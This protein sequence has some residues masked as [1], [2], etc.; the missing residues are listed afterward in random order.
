MEIKKLLI[1]T[2][3]LL[4]AACS[5]GNTSED[6]S[7]NADQ[8][9]LTLGVAPY[10]TAVPSPILEIAATATVSP[11]LAGCPA[12][13]QPANST[14]T[15]YDLYV[16]L[17]VVEHAGYIEERIVFPNQTGSPLTELA[18]VVDPNWID[19]VFSIYE[20][21]LGGAQSET[22]TLEGGLLR[23]P[24]EV[25]LPDGCSLELD[26]S[27]HLE[28]PAQAG[29]FGYTE[30]QLVLTNWYPFVPPYTPSQGWITHPRAEFGEYLVYPTADFTVT[31]ELSNP[32]EGVLIAAPAPAV[33][34]DGRYHYT[35]QGARMFSFAV[36][37][38]YA[39]RQRQYNGIDISVYTNMATRAAV[40]A[41]LSAAADALNF[42]E[43]TIGP[44]PFESLAIV[45]LDMYDGLES[46][47]IFY[48]SNHVFGTYN[49]SPRNMLIYLV[50]HEIS[51]NWW[52]SQVGND[53]AIEP[54]LDEALATYS[55]KLFYEQAFPE[56]SPWW[57]EYRIGQWDPE[58]W[59]D[60]SVYSYS[61]YEPYRQAVYL[62]GVE[63]LDALRQRMGDEAFL[64][65]LHS[66]LEQGRYRVMTADDFFS[67]LEEK[68][69][70]EID[71]LLAEY[72][73]SR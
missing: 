56:H 13:Y 27:Y 59:V 52:F 31:L 44:Y 43:S 69:P 20:L 48:L 35:L 26:L 46:D 11:T 55:E 50:P 51:H 3:A 64:A 10:K 40:G 60:A 66:Y 62:R 71:D 7:P 18:L 5:T 70:I 65:F 19:G 25:P 30:S 29:F 68:Y 53:Q 23:V 17:G 67:L 9:L 58:G 14:R 47:G 28:F 24:L 49:N 45:Q 12:P 1:V 41:V 42:F 72:F 2:A 57:W 15:S 6:L 4:L 34:S 37:S 21:D 36:L 38:G 39:V 54:W 33:Q 61:Q 32:P 73:G 16:F 63:F 8:Q 22:Y